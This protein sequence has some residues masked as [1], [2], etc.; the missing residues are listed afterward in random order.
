MKSRIIDTQPNTYAVIFECGD[1]LASG[2]ASF[3][4]ERQLSASHFTAIGGFQDVT[5][6]YFD[7]NAKDYRRIPIHE[8]V[9][10][11]SDR[12]RHAGSGHA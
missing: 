11:P 12:R 1:E 8:Q 2:L 6:G 10:V 4:E 5:L 3:A 9:E 7:W